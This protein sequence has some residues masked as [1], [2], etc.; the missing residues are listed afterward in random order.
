MCVLLNSVLG[1]RVYRLSRLTSALWNE[2]RMGKIS[3]ICHISHLLWCTELNRTD[4]H[5]YC[6]LTLTIIII[7][8]ITK[9]LTLRKSYHAQNMHRTVVN[10]KIPIIT[11]F[12]RS[13]RRE[14]FFYFIDDSKLNTLETQRKPIHTNTRSIFALRK[15]HKN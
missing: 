11:I 13:R 7:I 9:L 3:F 12:C 5:F 8:I 1:E 6:V 15:Q 14:F 10:K 2:K 4:R